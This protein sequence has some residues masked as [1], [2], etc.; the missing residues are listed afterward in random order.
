MNGSHY[1]HRSYS[2][3]YSSAPNHRCYQPNAA[4]QAIYQSALMPRPPVGPMFHDSLSNRP[5][6]QSYK[7]LYSF[8]SPENTAPGLP[9]MYNLV[10]IQYEQPACMP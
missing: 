4:V 8:V 1:F 9:A 5:L 6:Q 10:A 7:T 2:D 3:Y